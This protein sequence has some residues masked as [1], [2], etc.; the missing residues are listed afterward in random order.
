M[1]ITRFYSLLLFTILFCFSSASFARIDSLILID[2]DVRIEVPLSDIRQQANTEF[3]I[4]APFRNKEV[5]MKGIFLEAL[6]KK[7]LGKEPAHIK[8]YAV[9]GYDINFD[10]WKKKPLGRCDP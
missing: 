9:D 6:I 5:R 3:V 7:Y 1:F 4:F 10:K 8:L 2:Q